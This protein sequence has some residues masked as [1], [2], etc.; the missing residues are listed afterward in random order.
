VEVEVTMAGAYEPSEFRASLSAADALKLLEITHACISCATESDFRSLF[1]MLLDLVSFDHAAAVFARRGAKAGVVAARGVNVSYSNE[2][3]QEYLARDYFLVDPVMRNAL[4]TCRAQ[5]CCE[6][7]HGRPREIIS[8]C[9]DFGLT[10]G[11]VLGS[12]SPAPGVGRGLLFFK[13]PF[14]KR[15][16]RSVGVL[17]FVAPHLHLALSRVLHGEAAAASQ[18]TLSDREKEVIE[19]L[20]QGKSSWEISVILGISEST[21]NFHV[22]NITRKLGAVNRAQALAIAARLGLLHCD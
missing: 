2:F 14:M 18:V 13:S 22:T 17:E 1:Q 9:G 16:E 19:W 21:V 6:A 11:Y 20:Q 4:T 7:M 15:D 8:L 12:R 5:Y 3:I 10:D